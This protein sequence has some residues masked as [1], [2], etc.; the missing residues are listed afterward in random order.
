MEISI[1]YSVLKKEWLF[2]LEGWQKK[3]KV[4][5]PDTVLTL[6]EGSC[7]YM[8]IYKG[9]LYI[10]KGY[11]WDGSSIPGKKWLK[12]IIRWDTDKHCKIASL[13]HDA[14][15]QL[16]REGL[17]DHKYKKDIDMLYRSMCIRGGMSVKEANGRLWFLQKFGKKHIKIKPKRKIFTARIK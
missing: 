12:L 8:F 14:L 2:R 1:T 11:C 13:V 17:L 16:M 5:L 15:C 7:R 10:K 4:D 3:F 9:F 6:E